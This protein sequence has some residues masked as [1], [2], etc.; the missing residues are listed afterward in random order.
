M[1]FNSILGLSNFRFNRIT[2]NQIEFKSYESKDLHIHHKGKFSKAYNFEIWT[3]TP[4]IC[5]SNLGLKSHFISCQS[6]KVEK[7][8][9]TNLDFVI[10]VQVLRLHNKLFKWLL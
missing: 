2:E 10:D 4:F 7:K 8:I 5:I 9:C 3:I 1:D 6:C